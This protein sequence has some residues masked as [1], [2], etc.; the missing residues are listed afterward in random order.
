M[1]A[2][3]AATSPMSREDFLKGWMCLVVQPWGK[4]YAGTTAEAMVQS[5]LYYKKFSTLN[6]YIWQGICETLAESDHWPTIDELRLTIRNNTAPTPARKLLPGSAAS[7]DYF[8]R[9]VV[10][11]WKDDRSGTPLVMIAEQYLQP[12]LDNDAYYQHEKERA[13]QWV[14]TLKENRT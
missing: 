9:Q 14:A 13:V 10:L 11:A 1:M 4:R 7:D 6:P 2:Q 3:H 8:P 5:E 12:F